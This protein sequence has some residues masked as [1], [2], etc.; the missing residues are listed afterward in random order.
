VN[1]PVSEEMTNIIAEYLEGVND[2]KIGLP[3]CYPLKGENNAVRNR[4]FAAQYELE[5]QL[6]NRTDNEQE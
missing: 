3:N 1:N 6:D 2:C 4:G 5:Q